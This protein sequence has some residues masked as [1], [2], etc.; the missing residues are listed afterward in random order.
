MVLNQALSPV[1]L[2]GMGVVLATIVVAQRYGA[3]AQS[4]T[5]AVELGPRSA[6]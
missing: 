3:P 6:Q 2:L 1:Q 5:L 4:A